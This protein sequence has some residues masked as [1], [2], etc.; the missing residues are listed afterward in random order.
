MSWTKNNIYNLSD[1]FQVR[2][3][4]E[5]YKFR[6]IDSGFNSYSESIWVQD[7]RDELDYQLKTMFNEMQQWLGFY[8]RPIWK[9]IR[10]PLDYYQL[11]YSQ[12][13]LKVP[14]SA[15]LLNF[16]VRAT[17]VVEE[18]VVIAEK[19]NSN[20]FITLS[21]TTDEITSGEVS[22]FHTASDSF[23]NVADDRFKILPDNIYYDG[24]DYKIKI[25]YSKLIKPSL[26]EEQFL[27]GDPEQRNSY[28]KND[29]SNYVDFIDVYRI[30]NDDTIK[31]KIVGPPFDFT[32]NTT[33]QEK[34]VNAVIL[35][36]E[37]GYFKIVESGA[38]STFEPT[39]VEI[40]AYI[41][42]PLTEQGLMNPIIEEFI[43]RKA[44]VEMGIN[45]RLAEAKIST[46]WGFDDLP[47]YTK[48]DANSGRVGIGYRPNPIGARNID[49][50]LFKKLM[51]IADVR[52]KIL[53]EREWFR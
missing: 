10:I 3:R 21:I 35:D 25:H 14:E 6:Q 52:G 53:S 11:Y 26:W 9:T 49:V 46:Q 19:T 39:S 48:P 27:N 28:T 22:V 37:N 8:P 32:T 7:E 17:E 45:A 2:T 20:D 13:Y 50:E 4:Q 47:A 51:P 38:Y 12:E 30:Y 40:N 18:N 5:P 16:G 41:G 15:W 29:V 24:T 31:A 36:S 1:R 42:Y 44:K 34:T 43:I 23:N 33:I